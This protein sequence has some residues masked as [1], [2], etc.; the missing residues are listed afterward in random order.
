VI[1]KSFYVQPLLPLLTGD[2]QYFVL[3]LGKHHVGLLRGTRDSI[4]PVELPGVPENINEAL[5]EEIPEREIQGRPMNAAGGQTTGVFSSYDHDGYEKDRVT[6]YFR[7]VDQA[8]QTVL[9]GQGIPVVLAGMQYLHAIYREVNSYAN[10]MEQ[11]IEHDAE[12][13][14]AHELH[15]RSWAIVEPFFRQELDKAAERY[16]ISAARG[17]ASSKLEEVV[18]AAH[19]A[20]VESLFVAEG[21]HIYGTFDPQD[22][23]IDLHRESGLDSTDL[24][25]EAAAQTVLN[26]GRVFVVPQAQMPDPEVPISAVFRY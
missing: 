20:R 18:P 21:K 12:I 17:H 6:R 15:E 4:Q 13:L 9:A 26:G 25:A 3:V 19:Y 23:R 2:G 7:L 5:G 16:H 22:N 14:P 10:L 11:G 8:M 24:Y 1:G